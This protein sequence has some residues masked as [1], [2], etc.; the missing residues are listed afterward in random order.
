MW[1]TI[2]PQFPEG[3]ELKAIG[4]FCL[5]PLNAPLFAFRLQ[6]M[7]YPQ[8]I[9]S[10]QSLASNSVAPRFLIAF[11]GQND[12]WGLFGNQTWWQCS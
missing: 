2:D 6:L 9:F 12:G 1:T 5:L 10:L 8:P 11:L 4:L 3:P 7:D